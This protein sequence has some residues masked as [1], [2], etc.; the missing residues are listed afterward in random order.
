M[1]KFV[2]AKVYVLKSLLFV[3]VTMAMVRAF[4]ARFLFYNFISLLGGLACQKKM[5]PLSETW[6]GDIGDE[7]HSKLSEC[8]GVGACNYETGQCM[9]EF[10]I[11]IVCQFLHSLIKILDVTG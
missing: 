10:V 8:G 5:C 7:H 6:F 9:Y 2:Q 4:L 1:I 11:L 3:F